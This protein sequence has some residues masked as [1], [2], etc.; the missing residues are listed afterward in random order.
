MQR[1][2]K[3]ENLPALTA[4]GFEVQQFLFIVMDRLPVEAIF[5]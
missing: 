2:A 5:Y 3:K 1:H 4:G